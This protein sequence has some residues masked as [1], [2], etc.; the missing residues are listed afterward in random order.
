M[1]NASAAGDNSNQD[2]FNF[3]TWTLGNGKVG[4]K[5]VKLEGLIAQLMD[6]NNRKLKKDHDDYCS[7]YTFAILFTC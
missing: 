1:T 3:K 2:E 4:D 7:K 5:R 6:R